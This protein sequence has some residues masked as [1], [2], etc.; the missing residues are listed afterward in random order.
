MP[1]GQVAEGSGFFVFEPGLIVTNAHV[2]GMLQK[3]SQPPNNVQVVVNSGEANEVTF[4]GQVLG[5]DRDSDLAVVRVEGRN[6]PAP[7]IIE[8][9]RQLVQTQKVY[10]CGFP[11]GAQLG[12]NI[13]VSESS[14]SSL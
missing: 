4:N 8:Q 13:T 7:L 2:L 10:I 3:K 11:F 12:K 9:A 6:L 1:N 14:V 5:V